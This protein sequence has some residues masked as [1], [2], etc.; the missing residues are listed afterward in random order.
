MIDEIDHRLKEWVATVID[1]KYEITF[2]P[3]SANES[4]PLVSVYLYDMENS[5]PGSG[6]TAR[7]IPIEVTLSYLLT[8]H[9]ENQ[10]ES[11]KILGNLLFAAK[12]KTDFEVG[13]PSLPPHFWQALGIVPLPHFTLRL[14][15]V[16]ARDAAQAPTIKAPP[17]INI[18]SISNITGYVL[19]P[20]DHPIQGAKVTLTNTK[21]V[22]CTDKKGL[23][24]IAADSK[25]LH[26]FKCKIDAKG[27]QFSISIP[28]QKP[29][30]MIHLDNLED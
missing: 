20:R 4:K 23:F 13:F 27:K 22:A 15:L 28:M 3:P 1:S 9:S 12:S 6:S 26:E 16:F 5:V 30:I 2:S 29:P 7:E 10:A 11:H 25:S 21:T 8:V 14:P 17:S 19:G 24:S 18:G